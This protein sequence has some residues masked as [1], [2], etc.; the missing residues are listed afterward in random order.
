[1]AKINP[2]FKNV[3]ER[4]FSLET[5]KRA[6]PFID[7]NPG[8]E[9]IKLGVGDTSEA[10]VPAVIA[11][12]R[13]GVDKLS[14]KETYT[15]YGD[16]Q[17]NTKL[18]Q[19][20]SQWYAKR[21]VSIRP[22]EVFISDGAKSDCANILSIFS[23]ESIVAISDPVYPAYRD[24][25]IIAG[26]KVVYMKCPEDDGFI[27]ELPKGKVDVLILCSPN[28]PT[29]AVLAKEQ[30]ETFVAYAKKHKAIIIFD[31]A[32]SEY[33]RD[34]SLP[35]SIYEIAGATECA[36]EIQSFSKSAGFTGI[37]LGWSIVPKK[38]V[39]EDS[40]E[41]VLNQY[42]ARRQS[43]M[44]NGA[45]NIAQEGGLAVLS[46]DGQRET[47]SQV[48]YY[49]ENARIIREGLLNARFT[50]FGGVNAPYI[51]LKCPKGVSSWELFDEFLTKAHIITTPGVA[52]GNNG[53]G[54]MRLSA[55]GHRETIEKA[56]SSIREN[57][58][59]K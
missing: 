24:S 25:A 16:E 46:P 32:Y 7:A 3:S 28:N 17:G 1:M 52:F 10:I 11:G 56:V 19:A 29:G 12:L 45:S 31:A 44:F 33:I 36:I 40:H 20:I 14:K 38:L 18:R 54:Y 39:A 4:Y 23:D 15:G 57:I 26:R 37:R 59:Q 27:P 48:D 47:Q 30:L 9:I 6:R 42:W 58:H 43:T 34:E 8:L 41:G 49:M 53:E 22:D 13:E 2:N 35:K 21:N 5:A 51:W 55:F 50:V